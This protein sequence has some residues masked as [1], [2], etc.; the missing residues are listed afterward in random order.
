MALFILTAAGGGCAAHPVRPASGPTGDRAGTVPGT[1]TPSGFEPL[2]LRSPLRVAASTAVIPQSDTLEVPV[3]DTDRKSGRPPR[4]A[5]PQI[6]WE[7]VDRLLVFGEVV[8]SEDGTSTTTVYPTYREL[9]ER[10]GIAHSLVGRYAKQ[11]DCMQRREQSRAEIVAKADKQLVSLRANAAAL[12]REDG[13]RLV[14]KFLLRLGEAVDEG[15]VRCDSS[16]DLNLLLRLKEFLLGG[17]DSRT[18]IHGELS[19]EQLQLRHARMMEAIG[20]ASAGERADVSALA[21]IPGSG[22]GVPS[23]E[24]VETGA[25]G[26]DNPPA[27]SFDDAAG[28][29]DVQFDADEEEAI[30]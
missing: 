4:S 29:V 30:A 13:L 20:Q 1:P 8:T 9:G 21:G 23:A 17:A 3:T 26:P 28:E 14:D 12:S 27:T 25:D 5:S 15:R 10:F 7:E 18:E 19:L 11:H 6:P 24:V 16:A 22:F 2:A